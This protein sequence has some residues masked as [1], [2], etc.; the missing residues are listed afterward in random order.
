MF[1]SKKIKLL[2]FLLFSFL[3]T[4]F[5]TAQKTLDYY[6]KTSQQNNPNLKDFFNQMKISSLDSIKM[7]RE[8]GFKVNGIADASYSPVING[9]GYSGNTTING[10]NLTFLGRV[11]R[12]F[13]S[14]KNYY[15][16]L[17]SF[18][19][20]IQQL[21]NQKNFSAL[22]L[23]KAITEQYL[24]AYQNQEQAKIDQEIIDIFGQE[25]LILKKLTQKSVFRQTDYLSFKV[26]QQQN[27]LQLKQHLADFQNN[28]GLLQLLSGD[29]EKDISDLQKPEFSLQL[30]PVFKES[31]YSKKFKTDSLKLE[32]DIN[33]INY[34]YQPKLS[35]Y[36]DGGYSSAL[37]QTPYKNFGISVG[38]SLN[39]PI[40]DGN[41]RQ[42][43][44]EQKKIELDTQKNYTDFYKKQFQQQK[45]QIKNQISKYQ[46]MVNLATKQMNYSKTLIEANLKQLPTG[47]VKMVDFILAIT[48][49][50]NLKSGLLQYKM[51][52][53]H[54]ENQLDNMILP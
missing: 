53:L 52:I 12:D 2:L 14:K 37:M 41:Q 11:S 24:L 48:N 50:T 45:L 20:T 47:D 10:N 18:S 6:L 27:E 21:I 23:R 29:E 9:Y 31:I 39:I 33:L 28:F 22:N 54:L 4:G 3:N 26:T 13:L 36:A 30:E 5:F 40:Y 25:D 7:R 44:L 43:S 19:L 32:N 17:N 34:S 8:F 42:L 49:Y 15:A 46:E 51:Q 35:V 16:K 38:F 1:E